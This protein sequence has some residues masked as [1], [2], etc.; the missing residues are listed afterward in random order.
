[1]V[2][3]RADF[4]LLIRSQ[5]N[6]ALPLVQFLYE[7]LRYIHHLRLKLLMPDENALAIISKSQGAWDMLNQYLLNELKLGNSMA[8]ELLLPRQQLVYSRPKNIHLFI[9]YVG[10]AIFADEIRRT[11]L[12]ADRHRLMEVIGSDV[13]QF[14][15][16]KAIFFNPHGLPFSCEG[17]RGKCL[18]EKIINGGKFCVAACLSDIPQ[19]MKKRFLLKFDP[20]EEWRFPAVE[21]AH[22]DSIWKFSQRIWQRY[23]QE[24]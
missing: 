18:T 4:S 5:P 12:R 16:K 20:Q 6:D 14:S 9:K 24:R 15:L 3:G 1:M 21:C 8:T 11:V 2:E 17:V 22:I 23:C 10:A 19:T 13:Y 7:P